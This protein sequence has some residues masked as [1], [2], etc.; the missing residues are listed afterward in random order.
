[1]FRNGLSAA[2]AAAWLVFTPL[3][4]QAQAQAPAAAPA[5]APEPAPS[6]GSR[7]LAPGFSTRAT[8]SKLVI[9][10][11]DMELFSM[12]GGGV[13]EPRADWTDAA[14]KHFRAA[15][16]ARKE[17]VGG[18]TE[19]LKE[20]DL[21]ELGQLN[22]LHGTVADA[23][24]AHHMLKMPALPTKNGTLDWTLGEAVKPLH[25]R[26]QA[27]YALFLW[28]RDSYASAERKAAM[29]AMTIVGAAFGVA[30]APAGGRQVGYASLVDLKTGRIVW[31]NNLARASGDLREAHTAQE[32]V[33]ALLNNFPPLK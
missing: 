18:N 30:I 11:A 6:A 14:H 33:E 5:A 23:V 4:V 7:N 19:E 16:M 32:T 13:L 26:T 1:M 25:D 22:A 29:V 9:V 24:F 12:S 2:L 20:S 28:V 21:D 10:P 8:G 27:D 3:A 15:L 31:F 17:V